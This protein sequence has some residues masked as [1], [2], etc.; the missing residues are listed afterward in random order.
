MSLEDEFKKAMERLVV[1][2]ELDA[3]LRFPEAYLSKRAGTL[4]PLARHFETGILFPMAP[5]E[6]KR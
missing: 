3:W 2:D 1:L 4:W 6:R 5:R